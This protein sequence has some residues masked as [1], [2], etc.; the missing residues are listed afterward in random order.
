VTS[1]EIIRERARPWRRVAAA[2]ALLPGVLARDAAARAACGPHAIIR[3]AELTST[4]VVV[5]AVAAPGEQVRAVVKVATT[6]ASI[7]GVEREEHA[8]AALHND[9]RLGDWRRLV[10][11][12]RASGMLDGC[13]YR[14]D[15]ALRG[16]PPLDRV[17]D[18]GGRLRMV[19]SASEAIHTLHRAS[20]VVVN[21]DD[22]L[23]GRWIDEPIADLLAHGGSGGLEAKL[24]ALRDEL[25]AALAG[26]RF[27]AGW[28][29]GDYWLGN[30]L[31]DDGTAAPQGIV[32]WDAAAPRDLPVID[33]LH[34]LLYT[35]RLASGRELGEIVSEHLR[36]ARW[37]PDDR[38]LLDAYGV[39]CHEGSLSSRDLLLL[40]WLRHVAH[41]TRQQGQRRSLAYQRWRHTNVRSVLEA[42]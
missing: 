13:R 24:R 36:G 30:V 1:F 8:L 26:G 33:L 21:G 9:D 11:V 10:P 31:F 27:L 28:I 22:D 40:Y 38:R 32:D 2:R 29:H 4:G 37:P 41:H 23:A 35:R 5:L 20:A 19:E 12:V 16:H 7:A 17:G 42:L 6:R 25:H 15:T 34:L 14:V 39:W 18:H 3:A